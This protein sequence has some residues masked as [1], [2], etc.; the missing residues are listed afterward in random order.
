MSPVVSTLHT[1]AST[2]HTLDDG[3]NLSAPPRMRAVA[4]YPSP[5]SLH[6]QAA[7]SDHRSL[8][9][10]AWRAIRQIGSCAKS[11]VEAHSYQYIIPR[12]PWLQRYPSVSKRVM[13]A[14]YRNSSTAYPGTTDAQTA[15]QRIPDGHHGT[16][17]SSSVCG[18]Q[19][20][21]GSSART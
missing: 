20:C 4:L 8:C 9:F 21:T 11:A 3:V 17:A 13:S 18:V 16:W 7:Y 2:T 6:A 10:C 12:R 15:A 19:R 1:N 5:I 14:S